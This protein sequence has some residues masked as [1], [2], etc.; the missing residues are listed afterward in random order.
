M[1]RKA[2]LKKG[3]IRSD[4]LS[5]RCPQKTES[6]HSFT[7]LVAEVRGSRSMP[8]AP[9]RAWRRTGAIPDRRA[10]FR[11]VRLAL[12][13][14]RRTL[15]PRAADRR[16][17]Y[18]QSLNDLGATVN[19]SQR[20]RRPPG[21]GVHVGPQAFSSV[22]AAAV[23]VDR[24]VPPPASA[25]LGGACIGGRPSGSSRTRVRESSG[26]CSSFAA[27]PDRQEVI[28]HT[29]STVQRLDDCVVQDRRTWTYTQ[30]FPD[31]SMAIRA[32]NNGEFAFFNTDAPRG[33]H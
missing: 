13:E 9:S 15:K 27:F 12:M 33:Y 24:G 6:L 28:T 11:A 10:N 23:G 7:A 8:G 26:L 18:Y 14:R 19:L 1:P 29:G 20:A 3:K 2:M 21:F 32:M 5:G 4:A 22:A 17:A 25:R 30:H 31:D 16:V